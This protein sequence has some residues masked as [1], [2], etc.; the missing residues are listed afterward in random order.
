M[1]SKHWPAARVRLPAF[2][3]LS[4]LIIYAY[5]KNICNTRDFCGTVI[6]ISKSWQPANTRSN[7]GLMSDGGMHQSIK[8]DMETNSP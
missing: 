5:G 4:A 8:S 2:G 6:H 7:I 3:S 1:A